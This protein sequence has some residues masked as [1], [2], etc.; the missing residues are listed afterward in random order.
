MQGMMMH[1]E[2]QSGA[3][4]E[5]EA[6][7]SEVAVVVAEGRPALKEP[8]R[9]AVFLLNDDYTTMEFVVEVLLHFFHKSEAEAV[10]IM[11]QIHQQGKGVAG[12]YSFEIAETKS[13]QVHTFAR[14]RGFPLACSVEPVL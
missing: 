7:E 2:D 5:G 6:E 1:Q 8:G 11:L 3:E 9:Y 13:N 10:Q 4:R 14:A 12:I